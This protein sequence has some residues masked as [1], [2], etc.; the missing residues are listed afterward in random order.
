MEDHKKIYAV[1]DTN[2]VV[3]ALLAKYEKLPPSLILK[4][5]FE[6]IIIPVYNNEILAE[7]KDVLSRP[8]FNFSPEKVE[9]L[10]ETIQQ[11][12]LN[13]DKVEVDNSVFPDPKD[14]VFFEVKMAVDDSY[15]ITGNIKHFPSH[16]MVVTPALMIEILK[17]KRII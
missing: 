9:G 1:I 15:L 11:I 10:L 17:D 13:V 8:K 12:G 7:Y 14:I 16:T 3:S 5:I 2:V 6:L 4:Y